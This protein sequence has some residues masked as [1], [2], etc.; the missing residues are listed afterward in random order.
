[1]ANQ[2]LEKEKQN[3]NII[4]QIVLGVAHEI[5]NPNSFVRLN[6][7]NIKKIMALLR[8]CFEEYENNHPEAQFGRF[9]LSELRSK[10]MG[11]SEGILEASLRIIHITDKLKASVKASLT[12]SALLDFKQVVKSIHE[13]HGYLIKNIQTFEVEIADGV[14]FHLMGH[15]LQLE[16]AYSI[17]LTNA[18]DAL[19]KKFNSDI[20]DHG[21]IKVSLGLE[22]DQIQLMIRD[23][24]CGIPLEIREK[25]FTPFFT[26]KPQGRGDGLGL[27]LCQSILEYHQGT[28]EVDSEPDQGTLFKVSLPVHHS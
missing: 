8:P 27:S 20:K 22:N 12:D 23:N 5:N 2:G 18:F 21:K 26:T 14:D 24:G 25:I 17:L 1:M 28:I 19:E 4:D 10:I 9:S 16:Q 6:A 3:H 13:S 15:Q 11:L 7:L